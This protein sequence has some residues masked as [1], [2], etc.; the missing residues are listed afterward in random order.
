MLDGQ[1]GAAPLCRQGQ[2]IDGVIEFAFID[3]VRGF[4]VGFWFVNNFPVMILL[5]IL[6]SVATA[7]INQRLSVKHCQHH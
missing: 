7:D 2:P 6:S 5:L 1:L 4:S 3:Y